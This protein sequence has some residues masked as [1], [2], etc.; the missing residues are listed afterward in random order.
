MSVTKCE[1]DI[2][3]KYAIYWCNDFWKL[4]YY[5]LSFVLSSKKEL[6]FLEDFW[7]TK[8]EHDVHIPYE[9]YAKYKV[10]YSLTNYRVPSR[11]STSYISDSLMT[12]NFVLDWWNYDLCKHNRSSEHSNNNV[13]NR[14]STIDFALKLKYS[15]IYCILVFSS[16]YETT[17]IHF[18]YSCMGDWFV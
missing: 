13:V 10:K 7:N 9:R 4:L 2:I 1:E 6:C 17:N 5:N 3:C 12:L 15:M 11:K 8:P 14:V 16:I 18:Q